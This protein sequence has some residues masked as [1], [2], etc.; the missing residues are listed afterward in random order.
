MDEE[1]HEQNF[2]KY[3]L[4]NNYETPYEKNNKTNESRLKEMSNNNIKNN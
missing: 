3:V 1:Y 2:T 4:D